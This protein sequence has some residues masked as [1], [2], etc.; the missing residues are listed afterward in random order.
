M[1]LGSP[2]EFMRRRGRIIAAGRGFGNLAAC[3]RAAL[4][5]LDGQAS[6]AAARVRKTACHWLE[7]W[8]EFDALPAGVSSR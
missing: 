5:T 3:R 2:E 8:A 1:L 4:V 7:D 6:P